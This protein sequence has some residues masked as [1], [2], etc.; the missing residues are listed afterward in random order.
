MQA[1]GGARHACVAEIGP[2]MASQTAPSG[3]IRGVNTNKQGT[4]NDAVAAVLRAEIA[5]QQLEKKDVAA[6]AGIPSRTFGRYLTGESPIS[7]D[8]LDTLAKILGLESGE[9]WTKAAER[10]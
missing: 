3:I 6:K 2:A 10:M 4:M 5:A 8:T 1:T 9:V 7:I